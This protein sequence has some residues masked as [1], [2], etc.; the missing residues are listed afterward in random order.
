I[1]KITE[2]D[3]GMPFDPFQRAVSVKEAILK[4]QKKEALLKA[5]ES[6][7]GELDM[8]K[9]RAV[10]EIFKK[11]L[12]NLDEDSQQVIVELLA[13]LTDKSGPISSEIAKKL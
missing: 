3:E 1:K 4:Y 8:Y 9:E 2:V 7:S 11:E 12:D 13:Y 10:K 6:V 5:L